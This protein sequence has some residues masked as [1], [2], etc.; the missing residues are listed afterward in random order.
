MAKALHRTAE[1]KTRD[2]AVAGHK[3]RDWRKGMSDNVAY[4]LLVYTALQIFV[5]V[6]AIKEIGSSILPYLALVVLVAGII[7]ACRWFERRWRDLSD[8]EAAD[9]SL[10][11][12]YRR[13]QMLLWVLAIGLPFVLTAFFKGIAALA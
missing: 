11:N 5:T 13:D 6:H 1:E 4:A 2:R 12:G 8:E 3:A 7:P 9:P 10:A